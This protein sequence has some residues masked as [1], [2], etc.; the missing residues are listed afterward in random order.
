MLTESEVM[1]A[2]RASAA[3]SDLDDSRKV[4]HLKEG[5]AGEVSGSGQ[6][7]S[8]HV[9][10]S[11]RL[12]EILSARSDIDHPICTECTDLILNSL[13]ARLDAST[14]ERDAYI[15]FLKNINQSNPTASEV[16]KAQASLTTTKTAESKA[17]AELLT[18]EKEKANLDE[19]IANLEAEALSLD[20]EEEAFWRERNTFA[21]ELTSFQNERDALNAA[22]EHDAQQLEQLRRTNVYNDAL[23]ITS[24]GTFATI[25]GLRLGRL[26]PK[27]TVDW[28]EINAAWGYAA[29]LLAT[30]ADKLGFAFRGFKLKPMGSSSRIEQEE[31]PSPQSS[32]RS[33]T[34]SSSQTQK[35]K[36]HN[37][38]LF[39]SG[40]I[41]LAGAIIHRRIN[42]G[43]IA[44]LECLRQLCEFVEKG[45]TDSQ[46]TRSPQTGG[47]E[48]GP[49]N[50]LGMKLPYRVK[51]DKIGNDE[52]GFVSIRLNASN[53]AEWTD[54]CKYTLTCCKYLLA[55]MGKIIDART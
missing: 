47:R 25:N 19:E 8:E 23:H 34:P 21:Q 53:D 17:F 29:L 1:P 22:Y 37:L 42:A 4:A 38:D 35:P 6:S 33:G 12:F 32:A 14:K 31:F 51:N 45:N 28:A 11:T 9:E 26:P 15:A 7:F 36:V 39:S 50:G 43:M 5:S 46:T 54:A 48:Q 16:S 30:V 52:K 27:H 44:F 55:A 3:E 18:L 10:T 2:R 41:P 49:S 40:D 24:D 13:K 20:E